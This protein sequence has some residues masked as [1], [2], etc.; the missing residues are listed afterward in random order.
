MSSSID[1]KELKN[2]FLQNP[3]FLSRSKSIYPTLNHLSSS[4]KNNMDSSSDNSFSLILSKPNDKKCFND[5]TI[6]NESVFSTLETMKDSSSI[7]DKQRELKKT[8]TISFIDLDHSHPHKQ[9]QFDSSYLKEYYKNN[10]SKIENIVKSKGLEKNN[11]C[12]I[13]RRQPSQKA[14]KDI[15]IP[16]KTKTVTFMPNVIEETIPK[17]DEYICV[18]RSTAYKT[19]RKGKIE[20]LKQRKTAMPKMALP[21]EENEGEDIFGRTPKTYRSKH[22]NKFV[23]IKTDNESYITP[24]KEEIEE[25]DGCNCNGNNCIIM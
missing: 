21:T 24:K 25:N 7:D 17:H 18:N 16:N 12:F 23:N 11:S 15:E 22:V 8:K 5:L 10:E 3:F 13:L 14:T 1:K 9:T 4:H 6:T 2:Y 19:S 20:Q